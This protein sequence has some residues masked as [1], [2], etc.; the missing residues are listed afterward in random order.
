MSFLYYR[1]P[2]LYAITH[3]V[4]LPRIREEPPLLPTS[5]HGV[6]AVPPV[7]CSSQAAREQAFVSW[8]FFGNIPHIPHA[9]GE[10]TYIYICF[11][12]FF[13]VVWN[14]SSVINYANF[15]DRHFEERSTDKIAWLFEGL[16]KLIARGP[17]E[18]P[19]SNL[20]RQTQGF[21]LCKH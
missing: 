10:L 17:F 12:I 11:R 18:K 21:G 16:I 2:F 19:A 15:A 7:F 5:A 6:Q 9:S 4:H 8:P 20:F 14:S 1:R 3:A 13:F